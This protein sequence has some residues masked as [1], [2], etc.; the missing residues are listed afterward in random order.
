MSANL[1][2]DKSFAARAAFSRRFFFIVIPP[3]V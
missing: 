1:A 3:I 2:C